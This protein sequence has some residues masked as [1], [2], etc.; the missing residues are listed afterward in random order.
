MWSRF[1]N[2]LD[3][4]LIRPF[5][6][7]RNPVHEVALGAMIG[8]F[9]AMTPLVGVQMILVTSCWFIMK[10]F[11]LRFNIPIAMAM[12]WISNPFTM[13]PLYYLFYISGYYFFDFLGFPTEL[14]SY[15]AF[16]GRL[17]QSLAMSP[18]D[19]T[20]DFIMYIVRDLGWPMLIGGFVIALPCAFI[21]YP[22]TQSLTNR[23]RTRRAAGEGL[24][25]A[26]WEARYVYHTEEPGAAY[27]GVS[28]TPHDFQE[29]MEDAAEEFFLGEHEHHHP[30]P[31]VD[32]ESA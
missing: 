30:N 20:W 21:T 6:E 25:L 32:K 10:I 18:L 24:T 1:K 27:A 2:Y 16:T 17:D 7:S 15:A 8:M 13:G 9:W 3:R 31:T 19:G 22:L 14:V 26:Q 23:Y 12:V 29:E 11:R 5:R 28:E 4:K